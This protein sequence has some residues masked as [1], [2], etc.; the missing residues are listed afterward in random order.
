MDKKKFCLVIFAIFAALINHHIINQNFISMKKLSLLLVAVVAVVFMG[1]SSQSSPEKVVSG[2]YEALMSGDF[3]K[4]FSFM[5]DAG[6]TDEAT[7]KFYIETMKTIMADYEIANFEVTNVEENGDKATVSV[8]FDLKDKK[9][10]ESEKQT[11][12]HTVVKID[13]KWYLE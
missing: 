2:Q 6:N 5:K 13:G 8:Q 3:E 12:E 10:N 11:E 7:K 9:S 4:A 1:C